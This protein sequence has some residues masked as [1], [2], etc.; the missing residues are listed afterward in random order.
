MIEIEKRSLINKSDYDRLINFFQKEGKETQN[1]KRYTLIRIER[2]DF[3]PDESAV[4][5]FR[6][7]SDGKI[8]LMTVKSGSWHS[9]EARKEY[10]VHFPL[11]EFKDALGMLIETGT[12]YFVS[13]YIERKEFTY[14]GY[15][16]SM[17]RYFFNDDYIIDFEKLVTDN[18]KDK[19][20]EEE[21]KIVELMEEL[22]LE[23]IKSGEMI[24]FIKRLNMIKKS[25]H[26]FSKIDIDLWYKDWEKYVYCQV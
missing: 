3:V 22:K 26:D 2:A 12:P 20:I 23:V 6:L 15:T 17:D 19:V 1:F 18:E 7:R 21:N 25:Q 13:V 14:N 11:D 4:F 5:D 24:D 9:G 10:E 8:G 16:V